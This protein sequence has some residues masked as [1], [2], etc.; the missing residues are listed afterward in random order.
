MRAGVVLDY[1]G[2]VSFVGTRGVVYLLEAW[3]LSKVFFLKDSML[4]ETPLR[5][6]SLG[7]VDMD[8]VKHEP[9]RGLVI[10]HHADKLCSPII[11]SDPGRGYS[12]LCAITGIWTDERIP[13]KLEKGPNLSN[14]VKLLIQALAFLEFL[15]SVSW[16]CFMLYSLFLAGN[17]GAT[18]GTLIFS[19]FS[20]MLAVYLLK[21]LERLLAKK[22]QLKLFKM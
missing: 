8:V 13:F 18:R 14:T 17:P 22:C 16:F 4:I 2:T 19:L 10:E 12:F 21:L 3:P 11:L 15:L 6:I 9:W 1:W 7:Y 5:H 20:V